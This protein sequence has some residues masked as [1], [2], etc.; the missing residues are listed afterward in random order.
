MFFQQ[1]GVAA[2]GSNEVNM[3]G[4]ST[5]TSGANVGRSIPINSNTN[6][7]VGMSVSGTNIAVGTLVS[8]VISAISVT[9]DT[10]PTSAITTG[11]TLT[12]SENNNA[13]IESGQAITNSGWAGGKTVVSSY[14]YEGST[15]LITTTDCVTGGTRAL[16]F[17]SDD[18]KCNYVRKPIDIAWGYTTVNSVALYDSSTSVN[19]ELHESEE[20]SLV[21]RVLA[22]AGISIKDTSIYQIATAEENKKIQQEK[23]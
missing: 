22:L 15:T 7:K 12:F 11:T 3:I 13:F 23:Q 2:A 10:L 21:I 6:I 17:A 19:S 20:T 14:G 9:L 1:T 18:I 5:T 4:T 16:V 8:A